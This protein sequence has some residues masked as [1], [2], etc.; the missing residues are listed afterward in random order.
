MGQGGSLL[1]LIDINHKIMQGLRP[2]AR[3][4]N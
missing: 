3:G 2:A 1:D 4:D